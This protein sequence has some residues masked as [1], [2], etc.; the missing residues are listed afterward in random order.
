MVSGDYYRVASYRE[1]HLYD[2]YGVVSKE[3]DKALYTYVQ[4]LNRPNYKSRVLQIPGLDENTR[5]QVKIHDWQTGNEIPEFTLHG[6]TLKNAGITLEAA[7]G[8]F[9]SCLIE[10]T[11]I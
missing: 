8:D 4:V 5:Y 3:K 6:D 9:V 1:N 2:F 7:K 11:K 10:I